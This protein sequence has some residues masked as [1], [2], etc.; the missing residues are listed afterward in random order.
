MKNKENPKISCHSYNISLSLFFCKAD[1]IQSQMLFYDIFLILLSVVAL[2]KAIYQLLRYGKG[3]SSLP[4][5]LG[6]KEQKIVEFAEPPV[7]IHA[8]SLGE[9]RASLPIIEH[10]NKEGVPF[11][12]ST[13]TQTG[14]QE[15]KKLA[16]SAKGVFYLP[17]D[18]RWLIVPFVKKIKPKALIIVESDFW[19]NFLKSAKNEGAKVI[20][21]N[22][23]LSERSTKLFQKIPF[24]S[25]ALFSKIDHFFVQGPIHKSR[26]LKLGIPDV[27]ITACNNLKWAAKPKLLQAKELAQFAASLGIK[28]NEPVVVFGSTHRGEE[29]LFLDAISLMDPLKAI[30]VPRH[31]E[32]FDEVEMLL[33]K[34]G[35]SHFRYSMGGKGDIVLMDQMGKLN[36][37]YQLGKI[38]CVGGSFVPGIGG[39]NILEPLFAGVPVCF[40]PYM[41]GQLELA[42]YVVER[43]CGVQV[44]AKSLALTMQKLL[45]DP[46]KRGEMAA[47][48][49]T[50]LAEQNSGIEQIFSYLG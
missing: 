24:F 31:P 9:V 44:Q 29:E 13:G 16:A 14:Q 4:F 12:F 38:A 40:G 28:P 22:G 47:S 6:L 26:F 45:C 49:K 42:S 21:V 3:K 34:R 18:F 35:V 27:K 32:R 39:H 43:S 11:V 25:R 36:Y 8:V 20:L 33:K 50:L 17:F 2:P 41:E 30:I 48:A 10:L 15:A 5:K 23:K 37:C 46:V 7:W 19:L 1:K